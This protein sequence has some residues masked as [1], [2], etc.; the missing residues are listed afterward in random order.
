MHNEDGEVDVTADININNQPGNY[1]H[2]LPENHVPGEASVTLSDSLWH[3]NTPIAGRA[4]PAAEAI[5]DPSATASLPSPTDPVPTLNTPASDAFVSEIPP[6]AARSSSSAAS[7]TLS[8]GNFVLPTGIAVLRERQLPKDESVA[9][10]EAGNE[11]TMPIQ[12][13]SEQPA[14]RILSLPSSH[15]LSNPCPGQTQIDEVGDV[16]Q[17]YDQQSYEPELEF[18]PSPVPSPAPSVDFVTEEQK[19]ANAQKLAEQVL[20]W[21]VSLHIDSVTADI[22]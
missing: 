10:V 8:S 20:V 1:V 11:E 2:E 19:K 9:V 5:N 13:P 17:T 7:P 4:Q 14:V 21:F 3:V 6:P 18:A 15:F 16:Q 22:L 12:A